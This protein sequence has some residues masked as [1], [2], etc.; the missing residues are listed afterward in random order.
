[1]GSPT[2]PLP[3]GSGVINIIELSY[4]IPAT[5]IDVHVNPIVLV[6]IF[7]FFGIVFLY[8]IFMSKSFR[9]MEIDQA[10]I[11]V[12]SGKIKLKPNITDRQVAYQIWVELSTRK[13]GLDIDLDNDVIA[14]IYDSWH[15]FFAVTR[16]LIKSIPVS[17]ITE[18]STR[19]IINLSI[20]VLNEGLRPH[21][22]R[23][24]ARFRSWNSSNEKTATAVHEDPQVRQKVFPQYTELADDL[25]EVNKRLKA[26]R[27]TLQRL[28][29]GAGIATQRVPLAVPGSEAAL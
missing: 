27:T 3:S 4:N 17:K 25:L 28:V 5:T 18:P 23:W 2:S 21:L 1:M 6:I 19:Q 26:Y 15:S 10:E 29:Y 7:L 22:T 13:I 11:G 20:D 14:E 8:K 12:G 16:D 24:Q 9:S